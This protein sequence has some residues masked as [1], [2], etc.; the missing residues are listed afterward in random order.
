MS[1]TKVTPSLVT[2]SLV[3][4]LI[5]RDA[6][7]QAKYGTSM[8]REDL[9]LEEWLQH[10]TEE[11]LD[12]AGYA[13]AA[14]REVIKMQNE[15]SVLRGIIM[16][17]AI[18]RRAL[19]KTLLEMSGTLQHKTPDYRDGAHAFMARLQGLVTAHDHS[20]LMRIAIGK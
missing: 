13:T 7:G 8:D 6:H 12:G 10:Q 18:L 2:Q 9:T 17:Y 19:D 20:A 3:Q 15:I 16:E 1:E 14:K 11:L 5:D 4:Q